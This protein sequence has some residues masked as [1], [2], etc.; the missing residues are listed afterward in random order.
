[1]SSN[2]TVQNYA[3]QGNIKHHLAQ[4]NSSAQRSAASS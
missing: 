3:Y 2:N 4:S 1:M